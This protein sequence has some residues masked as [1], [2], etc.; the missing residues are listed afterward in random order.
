LPDKRAGAWGQGITAEKMKE[1]QWLKPLAVAEIE[2]AEWTPDD[3][4]RHASFVGLRRDK[5][6]RDVVKETI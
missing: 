3:R 5:K 2:F 1:C 6:P 4:L